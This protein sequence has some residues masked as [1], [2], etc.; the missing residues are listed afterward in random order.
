MSDLQKGIDKFK[1]KF[2]E[3][4]KGFD[5]R[6]EDFKLGVM[7]KEARKEAHLTQKELAE[8]IHT[9]ESAISRL[10]N[11]SENISINMLRKIASALGMALNIS[12]EKEI[13]DR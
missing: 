9:K 2:P 4:A 10:E 3:K 7:L 11:H 12:L 8:K 1:K 6:Y 13:L 5:E